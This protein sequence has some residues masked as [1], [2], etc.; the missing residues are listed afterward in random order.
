[1]KIIGITM[2]DPASIGPEITAKALSDPA[3]YKRCKP[4]VVGDA[5]VMEEALKITGLSG[6]LKIHKIGDVSEALY[7]YGSIDETFAPE[8][9]DL[10]AEWIGK[11]TGS[12][13]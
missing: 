1:M 12:S 5:A 8:A 10:I 6:K 9:L 13:R 7:E 2:G 11:T 3:V 4:L